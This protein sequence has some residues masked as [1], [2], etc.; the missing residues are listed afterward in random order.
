MTRMH[1]SLAAAL[2][3]ALP[4]VAGAQSQPATAAPAIERGS[5][6]QIEYTLKDDKGKVLESNKGQPPLTYTHGRQQIIPGL[7][8]ALSGM[9]AGQEKQVVVKPEDAYGPVNPAAVA[10]IPK[11]MLKGL[12]PES[13]KA[14]TRL[15]ARSQSGEQRPV[16]IKE[17]KDKTVVL[18]LNHPLAG[19]TLHFDVKVLSVQPPKADAAT[20][21]AATPDAPKSEAPAPQK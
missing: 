3:L 11:E 6:V 10:E 5:T 13:L 8:R 20:P 7:E 2:A 16:V 1:W 9:Q 19:Q 4:L 14:G 15:L 12:P 21:D 18:D 17:V